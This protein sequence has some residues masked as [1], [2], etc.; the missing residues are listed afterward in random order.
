MSK[1]RKNTFI[2]TH[3]RCANRW[4]SAFGFNAKTFILACKEVL[5]VTFEYFKFRRIA[6]LSGDV[7]IKYN[8]PQ[9]V[10]RKMQGGSASGQYFYQDLYVAQ[11]IYERNPIK[12]IDVGSR[13]DG[14]VAH[15]ASYRN[16]VVYDI[17]PVNCFAK[18]INFI[19]RDLMNIEI[20][21]ND[22]CDSL[23][24]LHALEHF[25]LGR[26]GD[27]INVKGHLIGFENMA[28]ILSVG[29]IFYLS[30][31]IG[32]ERVE[33]NGGRILSISTVIKMYQQLF[34]LITFSYIDDEGNFHENVNLDLNTIETNANCS[35]GCGIFELRKIRQDLI[36]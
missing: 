17:R 1:L 34:E 35:N 24:C 16:I 31:P 12:H 19:Q 13:V 36:L 30:I 10:D 3:I 33:F 7:N 29:G 9:Y 11:K 28:R 26:Y 8:S 4:L 5:P 18:S 14:F 21:I 23:S 2:H 22:L 6:L 20:S 15:V 25:G 27:P 32:P